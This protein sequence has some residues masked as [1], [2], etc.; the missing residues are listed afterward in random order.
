MFSTSRRFVLGGTVRNEAR[1]AQIALYS[2]SRSPRSFTVPITLVEG[3][4]NNANWPTL[5]IVAPTCAWPDIFCG[6]RSLRVALTAFLSTCAG[7]H[8]VGLRVCSPDPYRH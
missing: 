2:Y 8:A 5:I 6:L 7:L 3:D 1:A 4:L